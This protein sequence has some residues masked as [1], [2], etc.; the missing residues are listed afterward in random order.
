[1]APEP[2]EP[3]ERDPSVAGSRAKTRRQDSS[4]TSTSLAPSAREA[5]SVRDAVDAITA[6]VDTLR[7]RAAGARTIVALAGPPAAG[8]STLSDTLMRRLG[9]SAII[10]PMDGF[11]LDNTIL[12]ERGLRARKGAP[13]TFDVAGFASALGRVRRDKG[14]VIVPAFDRNLDVARAGAIEIAPRHRTVVVEGNYLL[15][16][17]TPWSSLAR[18]YD[19]TVFLRVPETLVEE[20]IL[21]RWR[22]HGLDNRAA[23]TRALENDVPNATHVLRSSQQADLTLDERGRPVTESAAG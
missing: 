13:A 12:D 2:M 1:M 18:A 23:R 3:L 21:A 9:S 19:G 11:H 5:L 8:K 22:R 16:N 4:G 7:A 10:L 14:S 17:E 15:L 6:F 20:R